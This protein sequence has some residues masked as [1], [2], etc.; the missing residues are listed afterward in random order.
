MTALSESSLW[1]RQKRPVIDEFLQAHK[2]VENKVAGQ[3]FL[4]RPGFLSDMATGIERAAK[5]KLSEINYSIIEQMITREL[6][7]TGH[8]YEIAVKE[9]M[10]AWELEKTQT[11]TI[12]E[13]EL[14][15]LKYAR[16]LSW[17]DIVRLQAELDLRQI[18][19][20]STK[21]DIDEQVEAYRQQLVEIDGQSIPYEQA[22][23]TAQL[24][25]ANKK[26]TIIPYIETIL[27]KEQSLLTKEQS[28]MG[29]KGALLTEQRA[30]IPKTKE[31]QAARIVLAANKQTLVDA[32][33]ELATKKKSLIDA[34]DALIDK[35][36]ELVTKKGLIVDEIRE[37]LTDK[38]THITEIET[39]ID[40]K[41][42]TTD[43]KDLTIAAQK[44]LQ[45]TR[46]TLAK[47][48]DELSTA[49]SETIDEAER[50]VDK[51]YDVADAKDDIAAE[52]D[53]TIEKMQS[54]QDAVDKTTIEM[55]TLS[56]EK[57][58]TVVLKEALVP[59]YEAISE[60]EELIAGEETTNIE[61]QKQV[62]QA[63]AALLAKQEEL[64]AAQ[65]PLLD[66]MQ[67]KAE[68][69]DEHSEAIT[70]WA[71]LQADLYVIKEAIATLKAT[72]VVNESFVLEA[73]GLL[74]AA[75]S[76]LDSTRTR[77]QQAHLSRTAQISTQKAANDSLYAERVS[78]YHSDETGREIDVIDRQNEAKDYIY[79]VESVADSEIVDKDINAE[80]DDRKWVHYY[81]R[82][83]I[84]EQAR[85]ATTAQL[86]SDLVHLLG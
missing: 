69:Q 1:Y 84:K 16:A 18:I 33:S 52:K 39:L 66:A 11:L 75:R 57:E 77:L 76:N 54:L 41:E 8:S 14:A 44:V 79:D 85:I 40:K 59:K 22:L 24:A 28:N 2:Q 51:M 6:A 58:A 70:V 5:F 19:L 73:R 21:A 34:K 42:L 9:A 61:Y 12:L 29:L 62:F 15:E 72:E 47:R 25:T 30:I 56:A 46:Q 13:Q 80:R 7:A 82:Y 50:T 49:K 20:I 53:T 36:E 81:K 23:L 37:N 32:K 60:K 74:I 55:T 27:E 64:L 68:K 45:T 10:I 48:T 86:T 31:L 26:L 71:K 4:Y 38:K 3:G 43:A 63:N 17:E 65:E 83:E 67:A 78:Q 35:K